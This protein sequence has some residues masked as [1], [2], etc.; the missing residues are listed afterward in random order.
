MKSLDGFDRILGIVVSTCDEDKQHFARFL[1][2]MTRLSLPFAVNLDHC[3]E[4]TEE[5][6]LGHDLCIGGYRDHDPESF[7]E[8]SHRQRALEILLRGGFQW[9]LQMDVDETLEKEA[10]RKLR[11]ATHFGADIVGARVLDLW[12]DNTDLSALTYRVDGPF[13]G[14]RR[15]KLF[16]LTSDPNIHYYHPTIHAPKVCPVVRSVVVNMSDLRV[17]H[18]GIMNRED[19]EFHCK[20]WDAIYT[21]YVGGNPYGLYPYLRDNSVVPTLRGFNYDTGEEYD[22][23]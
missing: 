7:F 23:K 16:S 13:N 18:W 12:G 10:L 4:E 3:C 9:M 11:E 5:L 19:A 8:E 20:R 2:E 21:R 1:A 14:S 15:E 6:F 17:L 22:Y